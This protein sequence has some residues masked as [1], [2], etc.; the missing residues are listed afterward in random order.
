MGRRAAGGAGPLP[1]AVNVCDDEEYFR[2]RV[3]GILGDPACAD[4]QILDGFQGR[5]YALSSQEELA[6]IADVAATEG[7]LLDPVYTGKA[8]LGMVRSLQAGTL[9]AERVLFLHTGGVFGL[10]EPDAV[11]GLSELQAKSVKR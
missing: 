4:L 3:E 2:R 5:G 9:R 1:V 11:S 6:F 8:F 10:F 7:L